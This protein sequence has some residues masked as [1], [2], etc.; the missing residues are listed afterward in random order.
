MNEAGG[1]DPLA[2][3]AVAGSG[4]MLAF[5][6]HDGGV[7]TVRACFE[8]VRRLSVSRP[9]LTDPKPTPQWAQHPDAAV[10]LPPQPIERVPLAPPPPPASIT[11][12]DPNPAS[13]YVLRPVIPHG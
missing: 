4:E 2:C 1:H 6:T 5:G 9:M 8:P 3:M 7:I 12:A 11:P 10:N 13:H